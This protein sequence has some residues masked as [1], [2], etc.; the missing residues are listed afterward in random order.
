MKA[1][2]MFLIIS[3]STLAN[4]AFAQKSPLRSVKVEWE[5]FSTESVVAVNCDQF[6]YSFLDTRKYKLLTSKP[7]LA[8]LNSLITTKL[9]TREK[10]YRSIDVRGKIIFNYSGSTIKYCFDQ[11]GHF[12]YEGRLL[13]NKLLW[14]FIT[15]IIPKGDR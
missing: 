14:A 7:E 10:E 15:K 9:F 3:I 6:E 1:I 5:S 11:F 8:K 2:W 4:N 13:N 12:Y